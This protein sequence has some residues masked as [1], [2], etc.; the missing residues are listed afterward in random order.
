MKELIKT[1]A[2]ITGERPGRLVNNLPATRLK[3]PPRTETMKRLYIISVYSHAVIA[4]ISVIIEMTINL[5]S[6]VVGPALIGRPSANGS[7]P[8]K[9]AGQS[10]CAL[11]RSANEFNCASSVSQRSRLKWK[12]Q[13]HFYSKR[14][15][16]Y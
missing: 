7:S 8:C 6:A 5:L 10:N 14:A 13:L 12:R 11:N 9:S 3:I 4:I 2:L 15:M 16:D 1:A